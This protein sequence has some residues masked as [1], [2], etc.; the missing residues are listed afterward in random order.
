M[1]FLKLSQRLCPILASPF[2]IQISVLYLLFSEGYYSESPDVVL[3]KNLCLEAM[4]LTYLLIE[5][6]Q[7][8]QPN[9]CALMALMCFHASRFEARKDENASKLKTMIVPFAMACRCGTSYIFRI[10]TM[11]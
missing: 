1:F 5:N 11:L 8:N 9:V 10:A 3:R 4:R 2:V 7:T 6:E